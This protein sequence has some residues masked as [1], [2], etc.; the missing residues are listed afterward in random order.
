MISRRRFL[1]TSTLAATGA[2]LTP[3]PALGNPTSDESPQTLPPSIARLSS[4][5]DRARPIT[6]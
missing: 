3:A 5:A 2:A 4:W 6:S 1:G